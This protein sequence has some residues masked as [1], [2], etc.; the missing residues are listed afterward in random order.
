MGKVSEDLPKNQFVCGGTHVVSTTEEA[1]RGGSQ[2][3]GSPDKSGRRYLK[4][5]LIANDGV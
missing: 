2:F 1:E 3:E 5:K 4:N